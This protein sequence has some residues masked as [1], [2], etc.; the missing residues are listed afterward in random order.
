MFANLTDMKWYLTDVLTCPITN[1]VEYLLKYSLAIL[2]RSSVSCRTVLF[3][4]SG[5]VAG[6]GMVRDGRY[7][8]TGR[9]HCPPPRFTSLPSI[10]VSPQSLVKFFVCPV[11]ERIIQGRCTRIKRKNKKMS[12]RLTL[13]RKITGTL[14]STWERALSSSL[15]PRCVHCTE[16]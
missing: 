14:A 3:R 8:H 1:E 9:A 5:L 2:L 13:K 6:T 11:S 12:S 7:L 15:T 10:Y 16:C 4:L